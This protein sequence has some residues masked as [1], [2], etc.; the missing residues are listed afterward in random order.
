[1]EEVWK[2]VQGYEGLYQVSN[3]GRVKSLERSVYHSKGGNRIYPGKI[4]NPSNN[5]DGYLFLYLS[6]N[7]TTKEYRVNRLVAEAFIPNPD[8]LEV[9]NHKDENKLNNSVENLEWCTVEYN[10][11]YSTAKQICQYDL[12]GRLMTEWEAISDASKELGINCSNIAQCCKGKR[13]TAGGYIWRYKE[14]E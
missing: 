11:R 10:N 2:D 6:K 3:L 13:K 1:M 12:S 14:A 4:L 8:N 5:G 9:V 7:G